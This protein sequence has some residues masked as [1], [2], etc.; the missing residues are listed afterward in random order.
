LSSAGEEARALSALSRHEA[1]H[2]VAVRREPGAGERD[3]DGRRAGKRDDVK[4]R[5]ADRRDQLGPGVAHPGRPGIGHQRDVTTL[6]ED[7]EQDFSA[8]RT[9]MSVEAEPL[10]K[11]TEVT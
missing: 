3:G 8:T 7:L 10:G 11:G 6:A 2:Q 5:F 1:E 4:S 9:G